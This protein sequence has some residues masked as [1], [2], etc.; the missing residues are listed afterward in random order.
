MQ[1]SHIKIISIASVLII[2]VSLLY[3]GLHQNPSAI[4]SPVMHQPMPHFKGL[5]I[6]DQS[7]FT[8]K[9]LVGKPYFLNIWATWCSSCAVEHPVW[10][11]FSK[12]HTINVV[13][14]LYN[15]KLDT[16]SN[17][18][19]QHGNPYTHLVDDPSGKL[20]INLGAYGT[21]ETLFVDAKGVIQKRFIGPVT[22]AWINQTYEEF[23]I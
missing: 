23:S 18:L 22:P 7:P 9:D 11:R 10:M 21:P 17:W 12:N 2:L 5:N 14:V 3:I 19:K 4:R 1:L 13:G 6:G 8:D 16:A 15:D 20:I